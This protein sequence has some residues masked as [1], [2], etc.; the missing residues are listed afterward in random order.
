[1]CKSVCKAIIN[2][3]IDIIL[4]ATDLVKSILVIYSLGVNNI[5]L[6][7]LAV[8]KKRLAYSYYR[9]VDS[10]RRKHAR[11]SS[12]AYNSCYYYRARV[13]S[14]NLSLYIRRGEY[15]RVVYI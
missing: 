13:P 14:T 11:L 2:V 1:M 8:G 9:H 15:S 5:L 4:V 7:E 12:L 10:T 3:Y 6:E